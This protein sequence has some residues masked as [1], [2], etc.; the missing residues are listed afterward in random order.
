[1]DHQNNTILRDALII[2]VVVFLGVFLLAKYIFDRINETEL[3]IPEGVE[4]VE[5]MPI[6]QLS[7][8]PVDGQP[9]IESGM[10][11][12][13][14]LPEGWTLQED[15][16]IMDKPHLGSDVYKALEMFEFRPEAHTSYDP[17][18]T[19]WDNPYGVTVEMYQGFGGIA[20]E[21]RS[22]VITAP[23]GERYE[24]QEYQCWVHDASMDIVNS[25]HFE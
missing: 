4:Q 23:S 9:F 16:I 10:G 7:D 21:C 13:F 15:G 22:F 6:T 20:D 17:K 14:Q 1:M 12:S 24:L 19:R 11:F 25:I 5:D 3:Y 2:I 18:I 8:V